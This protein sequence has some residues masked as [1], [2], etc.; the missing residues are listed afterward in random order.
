MNANLYLFILFAF[1]PVI[2]VF[3]GIRV[4]KFISKKR[5]RKS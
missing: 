5:K 3:I 4:H 1:S 2:V